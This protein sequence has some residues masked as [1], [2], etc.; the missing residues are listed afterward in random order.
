MICTNW[1]KASGYWFPFRRINYNEFYCN[2]R[3]C[4]VT[5][6]FGSLAKTAWTWN[7]DVKRRSASLFPHVQHWQRNPDGKNTGNV[8]LMA[9]LTLAK[10]ETCSILSQETLPLHWRWRLVW[11]GLNCAASTLRSALVFWRMFQQSNNLWQVGFF[12]LMIR[13]W[14][15]KFLQRK[16]NVPIH[17]DFILKLPVG[18]TCSVWNQNTNTQKAAINGNTT[19]S[20]VT[21]NFKVSFIATKLVFRPLVFVR[22][23]CT[24]ALCEILRM[25]ND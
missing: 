15:R 22:D 6:C 8:I 3:T 17:A 21:T 13:K 12:C 18:D 1:Q 4:R 20:Q 24:T 16:E 5:L 7:A 2:L 25:K 14:Q 9:M 10:I 11:M 23:F 19:L